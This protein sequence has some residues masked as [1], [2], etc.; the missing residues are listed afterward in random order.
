MTIYLC[1]DDRQGLRFNG[2]R[3]SKDRELIKD[4]LSSVQGTLYVEP[5]SLKL[6]AE[7][8]A[9]VTDTVP[10]DGCFFAERPMAEHMDKIDKLVIYKWNRAYPAD[11][12]FDICPL[13]QGFRLVSK[14]D[15]QGYSHEKITKEVYIK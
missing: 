8:T 13:E 4:V 5:Y 6:F 15:I 11:M 12:Y 9:A 1:L 3:Q 14:E 2:R 7:G 10:S